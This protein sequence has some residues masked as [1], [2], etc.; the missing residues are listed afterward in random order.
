[1]GRGVAVPYV[2]V[3]N[4]KG[5]WYNQVNLGGCKTFSS[6]DISKTYIGGEELCIN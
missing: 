1:M 2:F 5:K 6:L 4:E 3:E